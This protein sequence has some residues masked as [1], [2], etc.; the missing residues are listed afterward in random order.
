M[1]TALVT[2]GAHRIGAQICHTLHKNNYHVII[3]YRNSSQ[4]AQNLANKL[5]NIR[6]NSAS[7]MQAA[8]SNSQEVSKLCDTIK[9]LNLLV[10][11]ASVFYPTPVNKLNQNDYQSIMNTNVMAPLFLSSTLSDKLAQNQGCIVNIVDIHSERPLKNH[12]IYSISKAAIAMMTKTLAKELAPN[13]RVCGVS[14]GSILWPEN[15]AGLDQAKKNNMLKKIALKKQGS[16]Q[17]IADTV[18]FLANSAYITG[19]IIN[20]DG[21]RTLN[22]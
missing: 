20:V 13:V 8:L 10:N 21:G 4:A 6:Q 3:H 18:L 5:N 15:T 7:T 22:Q 16:A 11:N 9:S 19:Q 12:A 17:D 14:P 2:G 1:K